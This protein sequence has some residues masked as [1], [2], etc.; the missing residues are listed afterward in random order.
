M[1]RRT[2]TAIRVP[3]LLRGRQVA[4]D[5]ARRLGDRVRASRVRRRWTL[6]ELGARVGLTGTRIG[7]IERGN[8]A[9]VSLDIWFALSSAL[10]IPLRL[11]FGRDALE[12]PADAGHLKVQELMLRLA[13]ILGITRF[14]ELSTKP[15]DPWA[16]IGVCWRDADQR[17][18]VI[19][20]C[21]NTFGNINQSIRSTHRKTA[22]AE[23][24]AAATSTPAGAAPY[25]VAACWVVRDTRRNREIIGGY[26]EVF[27]SAFP[28]SS[29][30][31]LKALTVPGAPFPD[32]PGLV[33]CDLHATRLFAVRHRPTSAAA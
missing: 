12:Q 1:P 14:F 18:L 10:E 27:G 31:W 23:Q 19:N 17:V 5:I 21:W 9:G 16:S 7:Q 28:G 11:E 25:R 6:S 15:S 8:G 2:R 13:R 29:A 20:E 30:A 22:E 4:R 32:E 26:P 24:L 3:H 33:W